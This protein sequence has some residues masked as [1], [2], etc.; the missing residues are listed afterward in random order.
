MKL[1]IRNQ[2]RTSLMECNH[3][4]VE[5]IVTPNKKKTSWCIVANFGCV[6]EYATRER[7]LEI[8]DEIQKLLNFGNLEYEMPEK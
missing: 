2:D 1:W 5:E 7:C 3:I 6:G 4:S 8:I